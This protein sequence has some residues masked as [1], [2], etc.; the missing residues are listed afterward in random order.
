M[1]KT[2]V[3]LTHAHQVSSPLSTLVEKPL[4]A[5][6]AGPWS[7]LLDVAAAPGV[8]LDVP[9]APG[10]YWTLVAELGHA[11]L[12]VLRGRRTRASAQLRPGEPSWEL[13]FEA[14]GVD[15]LLTIYGAG[16]CPLVPLHER[17]VGAATFCAALLAEIDRVR[18]KATSARL[19]GALQVLE[20]SVAEAPPIRP[21]SVRMPC[22]VAPRATDGVA[23][24][25]EAAFRKNT[26]LAD[27]QAFYK[28]ELERAELH[29]LLVRG[30]FEF[31]AHGQNM[32]LEGVH[33]FLIAEQLLVLAEEVLE[34][35]THGRV[36]FRRSDAGGVTISVRRELR[37]RE[38][39]LTLRHSG[40]VIRE[41]GHTFA[42]LEPSSFA[43]AAIRFARSLADTFIRCDLEQAQNLRL[44][45]LIKNAGDIAEQLEERS[46][47]DSL[48][49]REPDRYRWFGV[50]LRSQQAQGRWS[51]GGK[52]RFL[53]R[54]VAC[55]PSLDL[56]ST[57]LCGE[58][59]VVGSAR[60]LSC[61]NRRT[62]SLLWR[63]P[64]ARAFSL[65]TRA[66]LVRLRPDGAIC[67]HELESGDIRFTAQVTPRP[68]GGAAG[69]VVHGT[70][71]PDLLVVVDGDR[72][73]TAIDLLTGETR[74]RHT[75]RLPGAYRV[76][77]AG[78]LV[79][80]SGGDSLLALDVVTGEVVWRVCDRVPFSGEL[81]IDRDSVFALAGGSGSPARLYHVDPWSGDVRWCAE[82]DDKPA[83]AQPPLL[84]A[85][86]VVV[87]TRDQ[88]GSGVMAL[89]RNNGA[90][91]WKQAPGL[92]SKTTAW[93]TVDESVIANSAAG[94]LLCMD[95]TS[96]ALRYHHVFARHLMS[97]QP[98]HLEPV[99]RSG[100]LFVPQAQVQVVRPGS[101]EI[102]GTVPSDLTPDLLRVDERCDV[103]LV[104]ESGHL[105]AFTVAPRLTL[106][107]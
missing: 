69:A 27:P 95:A 37:A 80:L 88:R 21:R 13:G 17:R 41:D 42:S 20:E 85:Q 67:L 18:S 57:F 32:K 90:T 72:R 77:R 66:G 35:R 26:A 71:L 98:R 63:V 87:S 100:A 59:L 19:L 55:V 97:D 96:G 70:G 52:M 99:L 12:G 34:S 54:W 4:W 31:W 103:Y 6:A 106:V 68:G 78:K 58:V 43:E 84:T 105:A 51:H 44:T 47:D 86:R 14:D 50:P 79:L 83:P 64:T 45:T 65:A 28:K 73:I 89:D 82:L 94:A 102:L 60:E 38:L 1:P 61:L 23:F 25:A 40:P 49:N 7:W 75:A 36:L 22:R 48:T 93:L 62:G 30:T 53:P 46:S 74:W 101:G 11:V 5:H 104:E 56:G 3:V 76:R 29:A 92:C 39:A 10:E 81:G 24:H 91:A 107:Q 15:L 8:D 9:V 33:P 16:R 2:E